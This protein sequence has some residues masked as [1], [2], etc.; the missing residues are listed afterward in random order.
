MWGSAGDRSSS[1]AVAG[2]TCSSALAAESDVAAKVA[3]LPEAQRGEWLAWRANKGGRVFF[4][5]P[6]EAE[7]VALCPADGRVLLWADLM[8]DSGSEAFLMDRTAGVN[9]GL[10]LLPVQERTTLIP[11]MGQSASVTECFE[12]LDLVFKRG[13][14]L[15]YRQEVTF[16]A[17]PGL[18]A[19]AQAILPTNL[20]HSLG[21]K[22]TDRLACRFVYR[23]RLAEADF[24]EAS[25]PV[26][27]WRAGGAVGA[28]LVAAA[29]RDVDDGQPPVAEPE[30]M[31]LPDVEEVAQAVFANVQAAWAQ[32]EAAAAAAAPGLGGQPWLAAAGA[33]APEL[34]NQ[35]GVAAAGAIA[36]ELGNQLGVAVVGAAAPGLGHQL[37]VV[38]AGA[39]AQGPGHQQNGAAEVEQQAAA[40]AAALGG[41]V[42]AE[43]VGASDVAQVRWLDQ[44]PEPAPVP[45]EPPEPPNSEHTQRR[46]RRPRGR[47]VLL[48]ALTL[49]LLFLL[50]VATPQAAAVRVTQQQCALERVG[51]TFRPSQ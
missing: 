17:V 26:R 19:L 10:R 12:P 14:P 15:E 46:H 44:P 47:H 39:A 34:G 8:E 38:A 23:P 41:L 48:R 7:G 27:G 22:G 37:G 16:L 31:E 43:P 24:V 21:A 35:L 9:S 3:A 49:L 4:A 40:A 42:V 2:G 45:A 50:A 6:S 30:A 33:V 11:V 51:G 25:V 32:E 13:T 1:Q 20:L 18:A 36:L 5:N 28:A 29:V